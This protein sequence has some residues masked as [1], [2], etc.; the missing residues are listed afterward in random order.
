MILPSKVLE[1]AYVRLEPFDDSH[2]DALRLAL[3]HDPEAW[4]GMV[5][6]ACG[7]HFESWWDAAIKARDN[8]SRIPFAVRCVSGA[9][10]G[11]T[12]IYEINPQHRRCEI[13]STFYCPD[14]R[15]S[16]L[17]PASKL[18]MLQHVFDH[19]A[20]RVEIVTDANNAVSQAAI[21]KLGATFE[22]ILRKHKRTW[23]G[24]MRDTVMFAILKDEDWPRVRAGLEAR[25]R[26]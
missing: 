21:R 11:T 7:E 18:L 15:G 26:P 2:R 13:G 17:N 9:V 3:D 22:G 24:R 16:K 20:E 14:V 8:G 23:T 10:V 1:N 12:S 5:T 25:L 4:N 19:G 6:A